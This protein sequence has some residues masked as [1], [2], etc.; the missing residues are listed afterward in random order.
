MPGILRTRVPISCLSG[1][2]AAMRNRHVRSLD[3]ASVIAQ[4]SAHRRARGVAHAAV[5]LATAEASFMAGQS[6][7]IDG[8]A[9]PASGG[10][11]DASTSGRFNCP[12]ARCSS[13]QF[14][15]KLHAFCPDNGASILQ[16]ALDGFG[17]TNCTI[18]G[19]VS[20]ASG[21]RIYHMSGQRHYTET[22]IRQDYGKR[23]FCSEQEARAAGWRR[24][25]L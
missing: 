3:G 4:L 9:H 25:G 24:S 13:A 12:R 20:V 7:L 18:K 1:C 21:E 2:E 8:T 23:Y 6:L 19:N 14:R 11:L 22:I 15:S 10:A 16:A 5:W 17:G